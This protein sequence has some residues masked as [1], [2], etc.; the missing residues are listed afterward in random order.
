MMPEELD[1]AEE[2]SC[3]TMLLSENNGKTSILADGG[4]SV[5]DS[6]EECIA[7]MKELVERYRETKWKTREVNELAR[8]VGDD[9]GGGGRS[10]DRKLK[11]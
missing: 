2:E 4:P 10:K 1:E 9:C 8:Q 7:R 3:D 5:S 6:S 11:R